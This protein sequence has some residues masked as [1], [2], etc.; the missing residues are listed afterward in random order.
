MDLCSLGSHSL[1]SHPPSGA[2]GQRA[3]VSTRATPGLGCWTPT[4]QHSPPPVL[5]GDFA[6]HFPLSD[7]S[8]PSLLQEPTGMSP[9]AEGS[10]RYIFR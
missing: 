1:S 4:V 5:H 10:V 8:H 9:E 7:F 6:H 2:L 3:G